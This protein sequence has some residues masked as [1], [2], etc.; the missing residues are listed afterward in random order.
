M[1]KFPLSKIHI[2][3]KFGLSSLIIIGNMPQTISWQT[4]GHPRKTV[5]GVY[6]IVPPPHDPAPNF[7]KIF[8]YWYY[9]S[10]QKLLLGHGGEQCFIKNIKFYYMFYSKLITLIAYCLNTKYFLDPIKHVSD[11]SDHG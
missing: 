9:T 7:Q 8:L 5:F 10:P 6:D 4:D 11:T 1:Q 2:C 3:T